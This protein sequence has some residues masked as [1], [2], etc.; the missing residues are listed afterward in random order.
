ML[1]FRTLLELANIE[2]AKTLVV[3]HIPVERSL[4][5]VLP[6]LV[7]E[8]PDLFLAYQ[9]IQWVKLEN[10]MTRATY[11]ASFV[12]QE[13][14][15]A[16]FAGVWRIENSQELDYEGYCNFPGNA[17]LER[18]GMSGRTPDMPDCLAFDLESLGHYAEWV[19]RLTIKWPMPYQQ[20][21]R[22][23]ANGQFSIASIDPESRFVRGM[24]DWQDLVL[25][26]S[27]LETLPSSW[28]TVLG[29]WR[30]IYYIHD[31]ARNAGYVGSAYGQDNL[32]GR[33]RAYARTGHGG[34]KEL[35]NSA[36]SDLRFS[37]LQRTSPD[38]DATDVIALEASWK[39]RLHTREFGLNRN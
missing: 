4:K 7:V 28:G 20:W 29:Q 10:A 6:W 3:R 33:W 5:R 18:L 16:T 13:R 15:S 38:M 30:G 34:N 22:W 11:L 12:S 9:Q 19:G 14:A 17:E 2:P 25:T 26:W 36:P 8:R 1:D 24:P 37:I 35:R 21:Y 39:A 23:A 27:E 32:L 31:T